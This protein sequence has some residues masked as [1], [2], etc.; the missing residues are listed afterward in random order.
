MRHQLRLLAQVCQGEVKQTNDLRALLADLVKG[1]VPSAWRKYRCRELPV[2]AWVLDLAERLSQLNRLVKN[3][4]PAAEPVNLGLLF[5]PHGFVTASRQT[6]AHKLEA[7]L[8]ELELDVRLGR[9]AD[10]DASFP[11]QGE[12]ARSTRL[13]RRGRPGMLTGITATGLVLAG[14]ELTSDGLRLNDGSPVALEQSSLVWL[15]KREQ[16]PTHRLVAIPCFLD[17]TRADALFDV[18]VQVADDVDPTM[19]VQRAVAIVAASD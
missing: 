6:V 13:L 4:V 10:S 7:S 9:G 19:V 1:T 11:L 8:E 16:R 15:R 14:A 12:S 5:N 2:A 17:A 18:R 3:A